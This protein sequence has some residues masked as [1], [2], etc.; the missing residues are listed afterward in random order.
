MYSVF[1]DLC[2]NR[3]K[4]TTVCALPHDPAL[5]SQASF[6]ASFA[7]MSARIGRSAD[8]CSNCRNRRPNW[9]FRRRHTPASD[10]FQAREVSRWQFRHLDCSSSS[11]RNPDCTRLEEGF[12]GICS[13]F[14]HHG[15]HC[16]PGRRKNITAASAKRIL[17]S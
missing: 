6:L 1:L 14:S 10:Y 5:A 7:V 9:Q 2:V 12:L 15:R 13:T 16:H 4:T 3:R 8:I 17:R 11:L